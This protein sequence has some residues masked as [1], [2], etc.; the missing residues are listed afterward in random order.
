MGPA[1]SNVMLQ[2]TVCPGCGL[3]MPRS[4]S[5]YD[6]KFNASA[7]CWSVFEE[8]LAREFQNAVLFGQVHQ[9]T[10]DAYAVQHAGGRHPDKSVSIHLVGLLLALE[11]GVAPVKIPPLLQRLAGRGH[12]PHLAPPGGRASLTVHDVATAGSAE[13]HAAR[14]REWAA[15]VWRA[16]SPHHAAARGLA[17]DTMDRRS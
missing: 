11:Q 8:V 17:G 13:V 9:L 5:T 12:W 14:V 4:D 10:V 16:W 6:R 1:C 15:E 7:E 3:E 2:T